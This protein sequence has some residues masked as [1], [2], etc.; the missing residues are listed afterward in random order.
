MSVYTN[1]TAGELSDWLERYNVGALRA[2]VPIAAGIENTNYFVT[3]ETGDYVLT[4]YERLPAADLPFYL[5]L[6]AHLAQ[7]GLP[8]PMPEADRSGSY[9]STL[10]GKPAGLIARV[11]GSPQLAPTAAHCA[12]IGEV[13]A[14]MHLAVADYPR[15]LASARGQ[16][17]RETTAQAVRPFLSDAQRRL[18]DAEMTAVRDGGIEQLPRGAIH[19]DL[20]RDNVLFVD[21]TGT[22]IGGI[23]DFGFAATDAF[24]YD[25]A[26]TVNDWCVADPAVGDLDPQRVAAMLAAYQ[27]VRLPAA[28]EKNRWPLLLRAGALRFWLSRLYDYHLPREGSLVHA[29]DPAHFER[30]LRQRAN[31]L[32]AW[33]T[34]EFQ[35]V[36]A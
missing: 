12:A 32:P 16:T 3:T 9:F 15:T 21:P 19:G 24:G 31:F 35:D 29:H 34:L 33:P 20:F 14:R 2:Q 36:N 26:V 4:L 28:D 7:A 8:V 22:R 23:I 25:L 10:N 18:L 11:A 13:L 6:M 1:V 30:I 17:W 27:K 5:D